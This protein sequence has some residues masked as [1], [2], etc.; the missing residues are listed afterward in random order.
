MIVH[1]QMIRHFGT[2]ADSKL[3]TTYPETSK[4]STE[5]KDIRS[6]VLGIAHI[7]VH[8][9]TFQKTTTSALPEF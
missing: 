5:T 1:P 3:P 4:A 9:D 8:T 7:T 6:E 2:P